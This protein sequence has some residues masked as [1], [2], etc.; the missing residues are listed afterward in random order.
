[1]ADKDV[2]FDRHAFTDK[3][4]AR[5]PAMPAHG[6]ILL[7]FHERADL[8]LVSNLASL[9]KIGEFRQPYVFAELDVV[10][11]TVIGVHR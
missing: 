3:S 8:D 7:D 2:V 1:V 4:V 11:N 9:K 10:G 6:Y 5:D